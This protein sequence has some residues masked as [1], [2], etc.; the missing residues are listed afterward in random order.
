MCGN[1]HHQQCNNNNNNN[2]NKNNSSAKKYNRP[3]EKCQ[4]GWM[5]VFKNSV[6]IEGDSINLL[7][8]KGIANL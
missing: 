2:K 1:C 5:V 3:F 6:I 7:S 4:W 8:F